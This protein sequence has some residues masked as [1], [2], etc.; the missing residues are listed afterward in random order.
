MTRHGN[1]IESYP[2]RDSV[3]T[4]IRY[5]IHFEGVRAAVWAGATL[6]ELQE[7]LDGKFPS[8]FMA[9][10]VAAYRADGLIQAHREDAVNR[11]MQR[12]YRNRR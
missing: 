1:R 5:G 2:L 12:K 10:V 6:R 4:G 8:R 7:W 11:A 9:T 3:Q